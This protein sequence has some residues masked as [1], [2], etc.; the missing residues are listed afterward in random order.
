MNGR[1]RRRL[2]GRAPGRTARLRVAPRACA[3]VRTPERT[4]TRARLA[5]L[6]RLAR[7]A[8][9]AYAAREACRF[10]RGAATVAAARA[11]Q[12]GRRAYASSAPPLPFDFTR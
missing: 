3:I 5:C 2:A 11:P 10:A 9:A 8:R 1:L 6:A 4:A 7:A 12:A